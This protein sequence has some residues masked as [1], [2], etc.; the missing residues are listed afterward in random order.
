MMV[1]SNQLMKKGISKQCLMAKNKANLI[2]GIINRGVSHQSSKVISKLYTSYVRLHLEYCIQFW[3][4]INEKDPDMLEGVQRRATKMTPS[5]KEF[6]IR[7]KIEKLGMFSLG[8]NMI[9]V[10][11]MIQGIDNVNLGEL[12]YIDE[13]ERTRKYSL[14]LKIR[15]QVNSN[16]GLKFF[17]RRY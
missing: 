17:T 11:K 9:E 13:D 5:F 6:I 2:L 12:F 4:P 3:S 15:R 7:G 14:C 8:R 10:F 1:R 16:I